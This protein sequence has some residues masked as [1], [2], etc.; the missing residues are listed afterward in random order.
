MHRV[1]RL[2]RGSASLALSAIGGLVALSLAVAAPHGPEPGVQLT[3]RDT[4]GSLTLTNS[5]DGVAIFSAPGMRP[6]GQ[7]SGSVRIGNA[8]TVTGALALQA[9]GQSEV[10]GVAGGRLWTRLQVTIADVTDA[11]DPAGVYAGSLAS[12]GQLALGALPAGLER[13]YRFV[14]SM[15][16]SDPATD[17][18]YQGAQLSTLLT[19]TAEGDEATP[20]PTTTPVPTTTPPAPAPLVPPAAAPPAPPDPTGD[21]KETTASTAPSAD[22]LLKLPSAR[23]C[24]SRRS[25]TIRLRRKGGVVIRSA[26]VYVNGRTK[27]KVQGNKRLRAAI[28]LRGLPSGTVRVRIVL[29]PAEGRKLVSTRSYRTCKAGTK[30]PKRR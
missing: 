15:P 8:G 17:N 28:N 24:I 27:V 16:S 1:H 13:E 14:V 23:S 12:M 29:T 5:K 18:S 2:R 10:A 19:W 11:Q 9:S 22:A 21:V 7:A 26:I 30:K 20:T 4:S 25:F 6:G 3:L